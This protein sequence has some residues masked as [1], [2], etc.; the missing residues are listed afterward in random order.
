LKNSIAVARKFRDG[1]ITRADVD[2]FN[3]TLKQAKPEKPKAKT[4]V[5]K[6]PGRKPTKR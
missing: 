4:T 5:R 2:E 6:K 3:R 1:E